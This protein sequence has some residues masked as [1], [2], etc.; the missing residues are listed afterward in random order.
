MMAWLRQVTAT[1]KRMAGMPDYDAYIE[2]LRAAH[3]ECRLPTEREYYEWYLA[4]KYSGG[5]GSRC[6]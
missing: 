1:F 5:P 3:P 2:H 4:G 6:C